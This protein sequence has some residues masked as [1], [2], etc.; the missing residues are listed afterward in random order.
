MGRK[1][2]LLSSIRHRSNCLSGFMWLFRMN[3]WPLK[4]PNTTK[5]CQKFDAVRNNV[6]SD[7]LVIL[8]YKSYRWQSKI[9]PVR[10]AFYFFYSLKY[11]LLTKNHVSVSL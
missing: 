8:S 11:H 2:T 5:E 3:A 10:E 9:F 6:A 1:M 4:L 7:R